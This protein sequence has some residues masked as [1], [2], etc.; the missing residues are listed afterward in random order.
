[1]PVERCPFDLVCM[2]YWFLSAVDKEKDRLGGVDQEAGHI[3]DR[4]GI[5]PSMAGNRDLL[6]LSEQESY[7]LQAVF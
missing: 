1:M 6:Q 3:R 4:L 7:G 2:A 5:L